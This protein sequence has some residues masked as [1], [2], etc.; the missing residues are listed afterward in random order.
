MSYT[1]HYRANHSPSGA[2]KPSMKVT[3]D[4]DPQALTRLP[5]WVRSAVATMEEEENIFASDLRGVMVIS[6]LND[7]VCMSPKKES[8]VRGASAA[9]VH[10][11]ADNG[12]YQ[13]LF[14]DIDQSY[15][16]P[17]RAAGV[18]FKTSSCSLAW[19]GDVTDLPMPFDVYQPRHDYHGNLKTVHPSNKVSTVLVEE[20]GSHRLLTNQNWSQPIKGYDR[21]LFY[22][23][24]LQQEQGASR[25]FREDSLWHSVF[26][27]DFVNCY[28]RSW[29]A[30]DMG[31]GPRV[32]GTYVCI[33]DFPVATLDPDDCKTVSL[34]EYTEKDLEQFQ[35]MHQDSLHLV[36]YL[37]PN[38]RALLALYRE[39]KD[40]PKVT[41]SGAFSVFCYDAAIKTVMRPFYGVGFTTQAVFCPTYSG[42]TAGQI[43]DE[44]EGFANG[45][46]DWLPVPP[47]PQQW[48]L[49]EESDLIDR[50]F[51]ERYWAM[52]ERLM[53]Q[54]WAGDAHSGNF[55]IAP[56]RGSDGELWWDVISIDFSDHCEADFADS[57]SA[58]YPDA[59]AYREEAIPFPGILSHV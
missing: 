6:S 14:G 12:K 5:G 1:K 53:Y 39:Q 47:E 26:S 30:D 36:Y 11:W 56:R 38:E 20:D 41:V 21:G 42:A 35:K 31:L 34:G 25:S 28:S 7:D 23:S 43:R 22:A 49:V 33:A 19:T 58:S 51:S 37:P 2:G 59:S 57:T 29:E 10:L 15:A 32:G 17:A 3:A 9:Y 8:V 44:L 18:G 46:P 50:G 45:R 13:D 16:L 27:E 48:T 54:G 52:R 40:D 4:V 55:G 24:S